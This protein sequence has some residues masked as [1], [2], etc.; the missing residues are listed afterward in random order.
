MLFLA[1]N[2][3]CQSTVDNDGDNKWDFPDSCLSSFSRC[4]R[5]LPCGVKLNSSSL[6]ARLSYRSAIQSL[7]SKQVNS[8]VSRRVASG[9]N[10]RAPGVSG[11]TSR[12]L[13]LKLMRKMRMMPVIMMVQYIRG[14]GCMVHA[15]TS[16]VSLSHVRQAIAAVRAI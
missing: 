14:R 4:G 15:S 1:P 9:S 7:S 6:C 16:T 5:K 11:T 12:R 2:Q 10:Y 8:I 3:Q 13:P